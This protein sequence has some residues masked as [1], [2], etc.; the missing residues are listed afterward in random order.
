MISVA[1]AMPLNGQHPANPLN[2]VRVTPHLQRDRRIQNTGA[3]HEVGC[4]S[5][6]VGH[7]EEMLP[8]ATAAYRYDASLVS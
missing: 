8:K 7:A 3:P 4:S 6:G 1:T 2:L 5:R